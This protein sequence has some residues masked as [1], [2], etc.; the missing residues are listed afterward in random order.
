MSDFVFLFV[1]CISVWFGFFLKDFLGD[2][3][4]ADS[5]S[6]AWVILVTAFHFQV[7]NPAVRIMLRTCLT[8][9]AGS[10]ADG[11]VSHFL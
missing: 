3:K 8:Y 2:P 4:L 9:T 1:W 11:L 5:T 6:M 10:K 7:F